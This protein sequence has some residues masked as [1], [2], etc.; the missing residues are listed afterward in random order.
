MQIDVTATPKNLMVQFLF[1]RFLIIL[2]E[3][4][5]QNIVK[6]PVIPDEAS[7]TKLKVN[8][9]TTDFSEKYK[10]YIHLGYIEW[11]KSYSEYEKSKKSVL[12]IMT[13]DTRNC[14]K[15]AEYLE[16]KYPEFKDSC[17]S[18]THKK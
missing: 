17:F 5:H 8:E 16:D 6:R 12:F 1:K 13:D 7:R 10:D 3:A 2:V 4:I 15:V 9:A 18:Y 14:D 11:K